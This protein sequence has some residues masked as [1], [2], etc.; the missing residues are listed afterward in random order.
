MRLCVRP[1]LQ[2]W[3]HKV[4]K[5]YAKNWMKSA[6]VGRERERGGVRRWR[7]GGGG[8][9]VEGRRGRGGGGGEEVEG[10]R[11]RGGGGG[12]EV[13]GRRWRGSVM[14][15]TEEQWHSKHF[16]ATSVCL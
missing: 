9:E 14:H 12:E 6:G 7:G 4:K 5:G 15:D 10:R 11:W 13:E 8:E 1:D 3:C 16:S 2:N